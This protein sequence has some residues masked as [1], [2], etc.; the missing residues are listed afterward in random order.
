MIPFSEL[1]ELADKILAKINCYVSIEVEYDAH[2]DGESELAYKYYD[3]R[4]QKILKFSS[5][6]MLKGYME[7]V[8]T[9]TDE[10]V[11]VE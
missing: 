10:G 1:A 7:S 4:T 6:Q 5:V 2:P 3:A 9:P 11:E 8:L